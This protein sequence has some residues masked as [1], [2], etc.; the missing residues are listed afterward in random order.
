MLGIPQPKEMTGTIF[1]WGDES[2]GV[3]LANSIMLAPEMKYVR[4]GPPQPIKR[5]KDLG[6]AQMKVV[7]FPTAQIRA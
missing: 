3:R 7:L 5:S 1:V 2:S 6:S 4:T